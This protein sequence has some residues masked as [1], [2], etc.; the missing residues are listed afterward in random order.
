MQHSNSHKP[1][2]FICWGMGMNPTLEFVSRLEQVEPGPSSIGETQFPGGVEYAFTFEKDAT[3]AVESQ[4]WPAL[5]PSG[6]SIFSFI[7][8]LRALELQTPPTP[9]LTALDATDKIM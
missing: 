7:K 1:N 8:L 4:C 6:Q 2:P 5:D 3:R 9:I